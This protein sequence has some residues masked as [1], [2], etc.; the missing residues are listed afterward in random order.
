M[1]QYRF[2]YRANTNHT[3]RDNTEVG[4][5]KKQIQEI[6]EKLKQVGNLEALEALRIE[7]IGKKGVLRQQFVILKT[8]QGEAK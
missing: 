6:L 3:R 5:L 2:L 8:L 1:L 7:V 4:N